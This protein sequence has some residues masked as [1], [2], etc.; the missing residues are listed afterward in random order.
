MQLREYLTILWRRKWIIFITAT[1]TMVVVIIGTWLTAPTYEGSTTLRVATSFSGSTSSYY[2]D[3]VDRLMNTYIKLA[4]SRPVITELEKRLGINFLPHITVQVVSNTELIKIT[5]ESPDPDMAANA[6][7]TLAEI[8]ITQVA[9]PDAASIKT[10]ALNEQLAQIEGELYEAQ[11]EYDSL[12]ANSPEDSERLIG[13]KK[14]IELKQGIYTTLLQQREQ[15]LLLDAIQAKSISIVE[16]AIVP[17]TPTKPRVALNIAL[18]SLLGLFGG[19]GLAFLFE[20]LDST[21]YSTEQIEKVTQLPSLG[22]IPILNGQKRLILTDGNNPFREAFRR[23]RA[24]ILLLNKDTH[25]QTL[26]VTSS[27]PKDGKS[28]IVAN[29]AISLAQSGNKVIIV[30][31]D[32]HIPTQHKFFSMPNSK[33]LS[34]VLLKKINYE[35]ILQDCATPGLRVLTTGPIPRNPAELL[36]SSEMSILIGELRQRFDTVILDTPAILSVADAAILAPMVDVAILVVRRG[37]SRREG[38]RAACKQLGDVKPKTIGAVI[39]W[40]EQAGRYDYY[41]KEKA[42]LLLTKKNGVSKPHTITNHNGKGMPVRVI[43]S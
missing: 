34:N 38:V 2:V 11:K 9:T 8:L 22:K 33:G 25:C 24:N 37:R 39:N 10:T 5:V 43:K 42:Q 32:M 19:V 31:C 17:H 16:P 36:G 12:V 35:T 1:V 27:E 6:A 29:L 20:N 7:N 18:G 14:T 30:D 41:H 26:L 21:L 15:A 28:T 23:L 3:L 13:L 4:T 40:S